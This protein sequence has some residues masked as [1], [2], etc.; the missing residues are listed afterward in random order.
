[1]IYLFTGSDSNNIYDL[2][3]FAIIIKIGFIKIMA[4]ADVIAVMAVLTI[5][6]VMAIRAVNALM[7]LMGA[8]YMFFASLD[9]W[10]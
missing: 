2:I 4:L 5:M 7:A 10:L 9:Y 3:L 1:M 6:V 8:R